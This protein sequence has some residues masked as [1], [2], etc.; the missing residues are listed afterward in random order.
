MCALSSGSLLEKISQLERTNSALHGEVVVLRGEKE[1]FRKLLAIA[2]KS[3]SGDEKDTLLSRIRELE[4]EN[5]RL[6]RRCDGM[7]DDA[8]K[9]GV[10]WQSEKA[11]LLGKIEG[12]EAELRGHKAAYVALAAENEKLRSENEKLGGLNSKLTAQVKRDFENSS[13]PSSAKPIHKKICNSRIVTGR[14]KGG[15]PGHAFHPR[16]VHDGVTRVVE[17]PA[18]EGAESNPDLYRTGKVIVKQ[19]VDVSMSVTVTEYRADEYRNRVTGTRTHAAFP[20]GVCDEVSYGPG[21]K[22]LLFMLTV[23][24]NVP[25]AKARQTV[26]DM[27]GG[28]VAPS[29]AMINGLAGEFSKKTKKEKAAIFARLQASP[30]MYTD[31]TVSRINGKGWNVFVCTNKGDT[32]YY[33]RE[34]KGIEG[35]KKTPVENFTNTLV[36]DHDM[37]FYNYGGSHQECLAHVSRYLES[38][39]ELEPG[40]TWHRTMKGLV[41]GA[42]HEWKEA[43]GKLGGD[44]I[45][46]LEEAYD[47]TLATA[48]AEYKANPPSK[49]I[50]EGF[51]LQKRMRRF[52]N[53]H[54]R[55]LRHP[56]VDATNNISERLLRGFKRK[57]IQAVDFKSSKSVEYICDAF[58][59]LKTARANGDNI[60][61]KVLSVFK[62][63]MPK[64]DPSE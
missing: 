64:K 24:C 52:R 33:L 14:K 48:E 25:I 58:G 63:P 32:L 46:E 16:K 8:I 2:E 35:V 60:H 47:R 17:I 42:I 41:S 12:M 21:V 54:L 30:V 5:G 62:S 1:N 10:R 53:E 19:V 37:T 40:L 29:P 22:A 61:E 26:S 57:Q 36:H 39:I 11:V 13:I 27:T 18:P 50:K 7:H 9:S 20:P 3:C 38:S 44:R 15:Q 6:R 34:K 23:C 31:A 51:N 45:R 43:G 55:F 56:E 4:T 49:Y 59:I 28:A